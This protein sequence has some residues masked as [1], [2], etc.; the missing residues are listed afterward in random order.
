MR[1]EPTCQ[2]AIYRVKVPMVTNP[3]DTR[4]MEL[5]AGGEQ[6]QA[7]DARAIA[8]YSELMGQA[9]PAQP[10]PLDPD[11][12]CYLQ[13]VDARP[14]SWPRRGALRLAYQ[15]LSSTAPFRVARSVPRTRAFT[16]EH[17]GI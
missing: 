6:W 1:G 17:G 11:A 10:A 14:R 12:N 8:T 4:Q 15:F 2:K 7:W 5:L 16:R 13:V 3:F 9:L